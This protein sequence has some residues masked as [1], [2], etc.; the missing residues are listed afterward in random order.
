MKN[1]QPKDNLNTE[2]TT[3][4]T[5]VDIEVKKR[6]PGEKLHEPPIDGQ[7][8]CQF[9]KKGFEMAEFDEHKRD[10]CSEAVMCQFCSN[11]FPR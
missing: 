6:N 1:R 7:M 9:C 5:L 8:I 3:G 11:L 10:G 4:L 2:S